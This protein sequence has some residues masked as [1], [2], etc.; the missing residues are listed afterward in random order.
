MGYLGD[1]ARNGK[2]IDRQ[3]WLHTGDIGRFDEVSVP[4]NHACRHGASER[5]Y[6]PIQVHLLNKPMYIIIYTYYSSSSGYYF[7]SSSVIEWV[8]TRLWKD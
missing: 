5:P 7:L 2:V 3:G 8:L 6:T 1:E 4:I